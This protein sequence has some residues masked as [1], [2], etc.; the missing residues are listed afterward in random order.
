MQ[1]QAKVIFLSPKCQ[2]VQKSVQWK[3]TDTTDFTR[4]TFLANAEDNHID[5][6][7]STPLRLSIIATI[8]QIYGSEA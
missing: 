1:L 4:P 6:M 8:S 3:R 7:G 2:A 5:C